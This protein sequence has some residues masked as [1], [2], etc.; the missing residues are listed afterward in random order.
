MVVDLGVCLVSIIIADLSVHLGV[1]A[2][3]Q[4]APQSRQAGPLK[5][6]S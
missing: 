2:D 3:L 6:R 1:D 4:K 5:K